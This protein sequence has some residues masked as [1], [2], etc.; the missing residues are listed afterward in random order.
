MANVKGGWE[1]CKINF[2]SGKDLY[3][4]IDCL[5]EAKSIGKK[6]LIIFLFIKNQSGKK[7]VLKKLFKIIY[8]RIIIFIIISEVYNFFN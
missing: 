6:Y 1:S 8:I 7:L 2:F 3:Y 5:L 4:F